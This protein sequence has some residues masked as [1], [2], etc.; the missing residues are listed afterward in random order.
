MIYIF[1]LNRMEHTIKR[2][3]SE[4]IRILQQKITRPRSQNKIAQ[5]NK[6]KTLQ[7]HLKATQHSQYKAIQ[8]NYR[9]TTQHSHHKA[10]Q[11]SHHKQIRLK[12]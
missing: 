4:R 7:I 11:H 9:K 6:H 5:L 3:L 2:N 8:H 12:I 1:I 10:T